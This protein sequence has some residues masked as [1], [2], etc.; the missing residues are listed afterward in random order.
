MSEAHQIEMPSMPPL[1]ARIAEVLG[2]ELSDVLLCSM[3]EVMCEILEKTTDETDSKFAVECLLCGLE[4]GLGPL[5]GQLVLADALEDT[6]R[7]RALAAEHGWSRARLS[8]LLISCRRYRGL[9]PRMPANAR[10][11]KAK[12]VLQSEFQPSEQTVTKT[13]ANRP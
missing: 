13:T 10:D 11:G 3:R 2:P 12:P 6:Q 8:K 4:W 5:R 9:G 1:P 7:V